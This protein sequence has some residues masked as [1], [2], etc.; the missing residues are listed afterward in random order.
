M[1]NAVVI[2]KSYG[3]G[4]VTVQQEKTI[5]VQFDREGVGEKSFLYP[6]AFRVFLQYE[7]EMLNSRVKGE[8]NAL[9]REEEEQ[10]A[11]RAAERAAYLEAEKQRQKEIA[12]SKRKLAAKRTVR[13]ARKKERS[14]EEEDE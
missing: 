2:H 13:S 4:I 14:A 12:A 3:R 9:R 8:L 1:E 10:A 6:D 5:R 11:Q 7:E